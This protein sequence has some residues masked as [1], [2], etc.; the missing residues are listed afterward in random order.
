MSRKLH[1]AMAL[2]FAGPSF[3]V[4][5]LGLGDIQTNS[6]LNEKFNAQIE[7]L[8]VPPGELEKVHV[9]LA[10]RE[11]FERAGVDRSASLLSLKYT[12]VRLEN[13]KA[14]VLVKSD[15]I[16]REPFLSFLIEVHWPTGRLIREYT[17]L[18]DPPIILDRRASPITQPVLTADSSYQPAVR[19]S[20][21]V[22]PVKAAAMDTK[23]G[24][25]KSGETLS[26]IA[27][28]VRH[29]NA[30]IKQTMI[31]LWKANPD[32]FIKNNINLLKKGKTLRV[33]A[34]DE[35]VRLNQSSAH[36]EYQR[37]R[38]EWLDVRGNS[39]HMMAKPSAEVPVDTSAAAETDAVSGDYQL[40]L[41][42]GAAAMDG[43]ESSSDG[44]QT[45]VE[46]R[47]QLLLTKEK[48]EGYRMESELLKSRTSELVAQ[49][50]SMK[51]HISA[52]GEQSSQRQTSNDTAVSD[53]ARTPGLQNY[54]A[55]AVAESSTVSESANKSH[56][57]EIALAEEKTKGLL[58]TM[59]DNVIWIASF[60]VLGLFA[61][62][63]FG[64]QKK[65]VTE[66]AV[67]YQPE[68][69]ESQV[70]ELDEDI[71]VVELASSEKSTDAVF[72]DEPV[73][74]ESN[75][76]LNEPAEIEPLS[77]A[78]IYIANGHFDQAEQ[79]LKEVL[80]ETPER[81]VIRYK[82]MGIYYAMRNV[83]AFNKMI[84]SIV[85]AGEED[86]DSDAW[87]RAM[88]M[89][90][91]LARDGEPESEPEDSFYL[92]GSSDN[93]DPNWSFGDEDVSE[94]VT[95]DI[96]ADDTTEDE[97]I[98]FE[99]SLEDENDLQSGPALRVVAGKQK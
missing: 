93:V 5:G 41:V 31:A 17:V 50:E 98:E 70:D 58:D 86:L 84:E 87:A 92:T 14:A 77:E 15:R 55:E 96:K 67:L 62:L 35:V 60:L 94:T 11:V 4:L 40:R 38:D 54:A 78:D 21:P 64:R 51:Q 28:S 39:K 9:S 16:I 7:L 20:V 88:E 91:E 82:L 47:K 45:L 42:T 79:L 72:L 48:A 29:Q 10:S 26:K 69:T 43:A 56:A 76:P 19:T 99:I 66:E 24:P 71:A 18:L 74:N 36:N 90:M 53:E 44:S 68:G 75:V 22:S 83:E 25:V 95:D 30:T 3:S 65:M 81:I 97:G 6:A 52:S 33:P 8:S 34:L 37:Q 49:L 12:A 46:L 23:Y 63:R 73:A 89:S 27:A 61:W 13:N 80:E 1:L 57:I 59:Y 2:V 85:A 32:A